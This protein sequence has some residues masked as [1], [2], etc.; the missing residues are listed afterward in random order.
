MDNAIRINHNQIPQLKNMGH[1]KPGPRWIHP[2]R[3]LDYH[4][5]L[6]IVKGTF[7]VWEQETE[8]VLHGGDILFLKA[9]LHHF[10]NKK[11]SDDV[12][13]YYVHFYLE[14]SP[15]PLQTLEENFPLNDSVV[16]NDPAQIVLPKYFSIPLHMRAQIIGHLDLLLN[17]Y[18]HQGT[19]RSFILNM[20]L[21]ELLVNISEIK[22]H[23][24]FGDKQNNHA[25]RLKMY[26]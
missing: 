9:G 6:Y 26:L 19:F 25:Y 4:D 10:G 21:L 23:S 22:Q 20:R 16:F 11:D 12:E 17:V 15:P 5:F 3:V 7:L 18:W 2:D 24:V 14:E 8:Y 13:W 1:I